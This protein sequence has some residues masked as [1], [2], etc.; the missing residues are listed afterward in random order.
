MR[1]SVARVFDVLSK[2]LE[3]VRWWPEV[4]I[5]KPQSMSLR[6]RGDLEGYGEWRLR[7]EGDWT[8]AQYDWTVIVTK[9]WMVA[10]A[11]LLEPVFVAN[12]RWAMRRGLEGLERELAGR[13]V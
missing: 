6:A 5:D 8:D 9:R 1:D 12:H 13:A 10:L 4:A 3:F 7:Q 2:P 11:P